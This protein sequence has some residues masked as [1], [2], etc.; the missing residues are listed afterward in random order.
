MSKFLVE[1]HIFSNYD[2]PS[3]TLQKK[4]GFFFSDNCAPPAPASDP[5][6]VVSPPDLSP[7]IV[8]PGDKDLAMFVAFSCQAFLDRLG[9][10]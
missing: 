8:L 6:S 9:K 10:D 5:D 1:D 3:Q 2:F 4:N 7:V